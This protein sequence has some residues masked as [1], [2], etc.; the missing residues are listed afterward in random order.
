MFSTFDLR[1]AYHQVPILND[2]RK[3]TGFEANGRIYQIRQIPFGVTNGVAVFQRLMDNIIKE[4]K[5]IDTFPYLDDITVA[6][7]NQADHGKNVEAFLDVVHSIHNDTPLDDITITEEIIKNKLIKLNPNK[8]PGPDGWH[9]RVLKEVAEALTPPLL[10]K[11]LDEGSLPDDWKQGNITA[12]HK[13]GS[14]ANPCNY[15]PI[16]LAS[17]IC[18]LFEAVIR[19][20]IVTHMS[21]NNL[22]CDQQHGFVPGTSCITQLLTTIEIWTQAV[23]DG[24]PVDAIYLDFQKVFD[25]VPHKRLIR[26][27]SAY[28]VTGE[29]LRW[30][31]TF[32][33]DRKQKVCVE[34]IVCQIGKMY[35][36]VSH[37]VQCSVQPSLSCS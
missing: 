23:D 13:K 17:I 10:R 32:L 25:S 33:T 6:G 9:P 8:L 35:L 1:N 3:Y 30:I 34:G 11:S 21:V 2:D 14:K 12:I 7:V 36:V 24:N 29:M 31:E 15:R 26:K 20:D 16:S 5:L 4:K 19:D 27:L 18:K 22:F 37:K 28:G